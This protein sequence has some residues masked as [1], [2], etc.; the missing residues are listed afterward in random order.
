MH[1]L[2][3]ADISGPGT[4]GRTSKKFGLRI[5]QRTGRLSAFS[6][7]SF[8]CDAGIRTD[9]IGRRQNSIKEMASYVGM[10]EWSRVSCSDEARSC[11]ILTLSK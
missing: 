5:A 6:S 8:D 9:S 1:P 11:L 10:L 4:C 2:C 3:W 7:S